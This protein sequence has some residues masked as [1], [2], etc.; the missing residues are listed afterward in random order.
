MNHEFIFFSHNFFFIR[1]TDSW[2]MVGFGWIWNV[3]LLWWWNVCDEND[4]WSKW[5]VAI[6]LIVGSRC[7]D[8]NW[9]C[10]GGVCV[11]CT[12]SIVV[13]VWWVWVWWCIIGWCSKCRICRSQW[14]GIGVVK[15]GLWLWLWCWSGPGENKHARKQKL[16]EKLKND[17]CL[18]KIIWNENNIKIQQIQII[19]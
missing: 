9:R 11:R 19:C 10:V 14:I 18:M 3:S 17:F 2:L 15:T 6:L 8:Q 12:V 13:G 5:S 1:N 7:L 16:F 4:D